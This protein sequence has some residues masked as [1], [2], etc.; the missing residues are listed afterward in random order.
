MDLSQSA[1]QKICF[2]DSGIGGLNLMHEAARILPDAEFF[3]FADNFKVPYG[4][5]SDEELTHAVDSIFAEIAKINPSAAVIACNTVTARCAKFLRD[6]FSFPI[7][8]IQPAVKEAVRR[9][10]KCVVFATPATAGSA[11]LKKLTDDYGKGLTKVVACPDFAA[12]IEQNIFN[13]NEEKIAN[14]LPDLQADT[15]VLGCTHY[16]FVKDAVQK[17]YGCPVFT[18]VE[19]TVRRLLQLL[20]KDGAEFSPQSREITFIG[21]DEEKNKRVFYEVL[22][23]T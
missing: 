18:G 4:S 9:G 22:C 12:F 7:V 15:V 21:G 17:K 20:G 23:R 11:S 16:I 8:G 13:L 3:Y 14:L 5:L 1:P 19:G 10:G 6:K 2:F